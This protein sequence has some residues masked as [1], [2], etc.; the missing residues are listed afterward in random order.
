MVENWRRLQTSYDVARLL[1]M[2]PIEPWRNSTP[3]FG[4]VAFCTTKNDDL[5]TT[6]PCRS[7]IQWLHYPAFAAFFKLL[8]MLNPKPIVQ[9]LLRKFRFGLLLLMLLLCESRVNSLFA[10]KNYPKWKSKQ[11]GPTPE[12]NSNFKCILG[13]KKFCSKKILFQK[14][15][16]SKKFGSKEFGFK[17]VFDPIIF[18]CP[19]NF[20]KKHFGQNFSFGSPWFIVQNILSPKKF[21][22]RRVLGLKF[23]ANIFSA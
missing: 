4:A 7:H 3:F 15:F 22:S 5:K 8:L 14:N 19:K 12:S 17:T 23:F 18:F 13:Q 1:L 21:L 20:D 6:C 16:G 2:V 10:I 9:F 11:V